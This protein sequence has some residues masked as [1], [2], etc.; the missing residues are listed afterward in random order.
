VD[1]LILFKNK[2]FLSIFRLEIW[3]DVVRHPNTPFLH[4]WWGVG[5][6]W[7]KSGLN[8]KIPPKSVVF[9]PLDPTPKEISTFLIIIAKTRSSQ[10]LF[11]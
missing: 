4:V 5:A 3:W 7:Q 1:F 11:V 6:D 9:G 2:I 8:F 10:T